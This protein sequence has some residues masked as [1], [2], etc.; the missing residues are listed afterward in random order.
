M[1]ATKGR[2][3]TRDNSRVAQ[4]TGMRDRG[5]TQSEIAK[6]AGVSQQTVS[7][8]LRTIGGEDFRPRGEEAPDGAM[9]LAEMIE[10]QNR[11]LAEL[12]GNA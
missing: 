5:L 3:L 1:P 2:P 9:T 10:A 6:A 12:H 4:I 8:I 11:R 7:R